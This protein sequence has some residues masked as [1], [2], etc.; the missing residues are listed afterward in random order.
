MKVSFGGSEKMKRMFFVIAI[1]VACMV[2]VGCGEGNSA[3]IPTANSTP[4]ELSDSDM[5]K[6]T[7]SY[8][9]LLQTFEMST[10]PNL[11]SNLEFAKEIRAESDAAVKLVQDEWNRVV[12]TQIMDIQIN[13]DDEYIIDGDPDFIQENYMAIVKKSGLEASDRLEVSFATLDDAIVMFLNFEKTNTRL[14]IPIMVGM[15]DDTIEILQAKEMNE[16]SVIN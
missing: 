7:D 2:L 5:N 9:D 14:V 8:D 10:L 4:I 11:K 1:L 3:E 13:S 15:D 12:I 16:F 6:L